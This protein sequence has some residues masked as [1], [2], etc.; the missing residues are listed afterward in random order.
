MADDDV[1]THG[2]ARACARRIVAA[3]ILLLA[4]RLGLGAPVSPAADSYA[5]LVTLFEQWR[6]FE[7][8]IMHG[9]VADYGAAAMAAKAA[10]L[11][12]WRK[13]LG[14]IDIKD[15][16][17][18]RRNDYKLVA[19]EMSGL[20]FNLRILRPWARD[21]AFY[22]SVWP[23]RSDVPSR[24][25]PV[26]YPEIELYKYR[27]PL[28]PAAQRE[29]AARIGAI[30]ELLE[31][32][33][34]NLKDSNARDLWTFGV[35]ELQNQSRA[36]ASLQSGTLTVSTLEGSQHADFTGVSS[37]LQAAVGAAIKASDEFIA[38]LQLRAPNKTGPSGVGKAN[39][40]WYQQ[41]VHFVPF[42]WDEEVVLLHR[43]LERAQSSLRLEEHNNR[44]L[45]QLQPAADAAAFDKLAQA[46]L[47]K[48]VDFLVRQEVIPD[49]PYIRAALEP[50]LGHFVPEEQRVFFTRVTHREPMLLLS[51]D[52]H[53][54]DLSR[55]RDEPNPSPIRRL[56]SLSNIWDG[57]A[58]GFATAFEELMMHA[59]LY[60]DNPRAKELVWIMLAN[61]AARGLASLYVQANV[62]ALQ[63]AGQFH[64][65]WTPRGWAKA[66]DQLTAFEQLLYLRQPGYGTSYITGKL[67]LDR[68]LT[69]YAHQQDL[70]GK[71]FTLRDFLDR[72]NREGMIPLPLMEKEMIS[73][74]AREP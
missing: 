19:A 6:E 1:S 74:G 62:F 10:A 8:P 12:K 7:R 35:Q 5:S 73:S 24:E 37:A 42:N 28:S 46:R 41:N 65:E 3:A 30:P 50:R 17:I 43:E 38:W 33:R 11:P 26:A 69:E 14:A 66:Q 72:F 67:L 4:A 55:M 22:V 25:G 60:D 61:R 32:A 44:Q 36:L 27:F 56:A 15:W 34:E 47:D 51:H 70:D 68:L 53:W 31:Q 58:E 9:E 59:G 52:Y 49:K 71:A 64:A 16:P 57:R 23:S 45:P 63:Q 39:Y 40:T 18:D 54:L 20:D 13:R 21:P 2:T 48:F 29:L